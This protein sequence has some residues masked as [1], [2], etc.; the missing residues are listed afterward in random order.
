MTSINMGNREKNGQFQELT[1]SELT[2]VDGGL[3]TPQGMLVFAVG[4]AMKQALDDAFSGKGMN[5]W[6]IMG[7]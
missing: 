1:A 2:S 7:R 3:F 5:M 6:E 4:Y